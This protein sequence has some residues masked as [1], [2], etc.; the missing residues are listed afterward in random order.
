VLSSEDEVREHLLGALAHLSP[1]G[2]YDVPARDKLNFTAL[3]VRAYAQGWSREALEPYLV[4]FGSAA[5]TPHLGSLT[6][7]LRSQVQALLVRSAAEVRSVES[8]PAPLSIYCFGKFRVFCGGREVGDENWKTRKAKYLFAYLACAG[9]REVPDEKLMELFWPD[10][11]PDKARQNFYSALSHIRKA[12]EGFL[13]QEY[14]KVVTAHKGFYRINASIPHTVDA[15]EFERHY[16]AATQA[17]RVGSVEEAVVGF[18]RA[19]ALYLGEF[20]EGYYSDWALSFRDDYERRYQELLNSLMRA[21]A[22]KDKH[23]VVVDY[24]QKLLAV[25]SC[26]QEAHHALMKAYVGLGRPEQAVRQYQQCSQILKSELN[27]TPSSELSSYY[28]SIKG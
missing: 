1:H 23:S 11:D 16:E 9:D 28:L 14:D 17:M 18:Q 22:A 13:P 5:L 8:T 3:F 24:C 7:A 25:D 12:L 2:L 27:M 19:E 20:L 4:A 6:P 10:H 21:F 26:D 15:R